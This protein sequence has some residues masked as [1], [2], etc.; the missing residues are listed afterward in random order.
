MNMTDPVADMITRIRNGVRAKLAKVDV[1]ASKLKVEIA[2]IL[3]DEGYISNFKKT[4]DQR[5]GVIRVYLKYGPG[6]ERVITDLQRVS[7]PGCRIYCGKDQI[8]RVFGGLGINILS[9]SR[10][11]MTGRTAAREGVGGEILCN[12]W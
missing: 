11:L 10:G 9:T 3:K 2:R 5:Q 8:P 4:E 12:V 6:M 1:P 7:R